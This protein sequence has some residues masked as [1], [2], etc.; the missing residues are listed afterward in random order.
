M[1]AIRDQ[2]AQPGEAR[3]PKNRDL[4]AALEFPKVV[5]KYGIIARPPFATF[6]LDITFLCSAEFR[7]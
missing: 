2:A 3:R 4:K 1:A 7:L 5:E 6:S